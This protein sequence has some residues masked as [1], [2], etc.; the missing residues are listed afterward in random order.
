MNTQEYV[1]LLKRLDEFA[2]K[3]DAL[4]KRLEAIERLGE[5]SGNAAKLKEIR[6]KI[7]TGLSFV[8]KGYTTKDLRRD[9]GAI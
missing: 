7:S 9:L 3:F 4:D 8:G 5:L 2:A 6:D 1:N